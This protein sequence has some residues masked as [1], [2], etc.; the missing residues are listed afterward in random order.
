M[1]RPILLI[2]TILFI[3]VSYAQDEA[4]EKYF[5]KGEVLV[6]L[7]VLPA[8]A[9]NAKVGYTFAPNAI[10]GVELTS[11]L[12]F[13]QRNEIG[14]FGRK[15]LFNNRFNVYLQGGVSYGYYRPWDLRIDFPERKLDEIETAPFSAVK[16]SGG[17]GVSYRVNQNLAIGN[18]ALMGFTNHR[19]HYFPTFL[20]TA[21]Y[22][23]REK[24]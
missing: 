6:E 5:N 13:T 12:L 3:Q 9:L 8:F 20:F 16:L 4:P 22:K 21:N 23:L 24:K 18:E 15:Y 10:V 7:G 2:L 19:N 17:G 14:I 1:N 11:Q